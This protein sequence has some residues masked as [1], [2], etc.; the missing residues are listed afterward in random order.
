[1]I[2]KTVQPAGNWKDDAIRLLHC[3]DPDAG[4]LYL[5]DFHEF[6][7]PEDAALG[8]TSVFLD[9]QLRDRLKACGEWKGRGFVCLIDADRIEAQFRKSGIGRDARR[10]VLGIV[11]HEYGHFITCTLVPEERAD[12]L[13]ADLPDFAHYLSTAPITIGPDD[14]AAPPWRDHDGIPFGRACIHLWHRAN[15]HGHDFHINDVWTSA[16]TYRLAS[17]LGYA[18]ALGNEPQ[19]RL[20]EPLRA[21][22][23]SPAPAP[24][25]DFCNHDL[26]RARAQLVLDSKNHFSEEPKMSTLLDRLADHE[27]KQKAQ[28]VTAWRDLVR[29]TESGVDVEPGEAMQILKAAGKRPADLAGAVALSRNRRAWVEQA[30][31]LKETESALN[32]IDAE[33]AAAVKTLQDAQEAFRASRPSVIARRTALLSQHADCM[34]AI[35]QLQ[36]TADDPAL[37]AADRKLSVDMHGLAVSERSVRATLGDRKK[38]LATLRIKLNQAK[39]GAANWLR[40]PG[41]TAPAANAEA[42]EKEFS[43]FNRTAVEPL[44]RQLATIDQQRAAI[45]RE[46][47]QVAEAKLVP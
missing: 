30:A 1:M 37:L 46:S 19:A 31:K 7:I 4:P 27:Q 21:I 28:A 24:Y 47:A 14:P 43:E 40:V 33:E 32:A 13:L 35:D 41:F 44:E 26:Q 16:D 34:S 17:P 9:L 39:R 45:N 23:N 2:A 12:R 10:R 8:C 29:R 18:E 36:R 25:A 15:L 11:L 3:V 38:Y 20:G 42:M 6:D 5:F 22:L